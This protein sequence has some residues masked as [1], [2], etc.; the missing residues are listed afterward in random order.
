LVVDDEATPRHEA[1]RMV[2][3]LGYRAE[4]ACHGREA[5]RYL[6]Q[7]P[8]GVQLVLTDVIMPLMDGGELLERAHDLAPRLPVV[9]MAGS[10]EGHAG[11]LVAAYPE[12]PFLEKPVTYAKLAAVLR[13]LIGPPLGPH[14]PPSSRPARFRGR[15]PE[16]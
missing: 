12:A 13:W 11:E 3:A 5:L 10:L 7:H 16:S 14:I 6:Q 8:G 9:F 2:R 4:T 15:K 1:C